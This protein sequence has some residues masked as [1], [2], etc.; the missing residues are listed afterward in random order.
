MNGLLL[1]ERIACLVF[2]AP[3]I[4]FLHQSCVRLS[5]TR[6]MVSYGLREIWSWQVELVNT[7]VIFTA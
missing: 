3:G 1:S 2:H 7:A 4:A 6:F 5:A